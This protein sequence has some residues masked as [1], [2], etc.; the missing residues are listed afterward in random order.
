M[1]RRS[2][3]STKNGRARSGGAAAAAAAAEKPRRRSA[4]W[5]VAVIGA[6]LVACL[7][8]L[9]LG[10]ARP[11]GGAAASFSA[12]DAVDARR[13]AACVADWDACDASCGVVAVPDAD[14]RRLVRD[15]LSGAAAGGG[16]ARD[17]ALVAAIAGDFGGGSGGGAVLARRGGATVLARGGGGAA[18]A[19]GALLALDAECPRG[20]RAWSGGSP[21]LAAVL[22][23]A[24]AV[25]AGGGGDR[26]LAPV[27]SAEIESRRL[28]LELGGASSSLD[29]RGLWA[30]EEAFLPTAATVAAGDTPLLRAARACDARAT[31][32]L[33]AL[34]ADAARNPDRFSRRRFDSR[35]LRGEGSKA[36][37]PFRSSG[38]GT[39]S[40]GTGRSPRGTAVEFFLRSERAAARESPRLSPRGSAKPAVGF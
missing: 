23:V 1:A 27:P 12:A 40:L 28:E 38:G 31:R 14:A 8:A 26:A 29:V 24:A 21:R 6:P 17:V 11:G 25:A 9:R 19:D 30:A 4:A 18:V 33:L 2:A 20:P 36:S 13:A 35:V 39:E 22:R 15:A 16:A 5:A 3:A 32:A 7:L 10:A 34:G 37:P